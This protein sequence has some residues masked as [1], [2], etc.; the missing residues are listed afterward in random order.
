MLPFSISGSGIG[1]LRSEATD[2]DRLTKAQ[3]KVIA[4]EAA[5]RRDSENEIAV[6]DEL[7]GMCSEFFM[8]IGV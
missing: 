4:A 5:I 3:K 1:S 7:T 2:K 8:T 6:K